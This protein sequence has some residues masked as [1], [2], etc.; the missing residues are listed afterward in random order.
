ML[1]LCN[2]ETYYVTSYSDIIKGYRK[3]TESED[4]YNLRKEDSCAM[5]VPGFFSKFSVLPP[6]S[7]TG[8]YRKTNHLSEGIEL[9]DIKENSY[10]NTKGIFKKRRS[11]FLALLLSTGWPALVGTS[12]QTFSIAMEIINPQILRYTRKTSVRCKKDFRQH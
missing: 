2:P 5:L 11:F 12:L 6:S 1:E 7:S 9:K 8:T 4:I 3:T 10:E